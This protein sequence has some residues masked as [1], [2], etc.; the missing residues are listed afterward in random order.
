[1]CYNIDNER[2]DN[3]QIMKGGTEYERSGIGK[4]C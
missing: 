1:M 4:R 3:L 2:R